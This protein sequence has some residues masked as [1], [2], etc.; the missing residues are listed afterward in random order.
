MLECI[1]RS[2]FKLPFANLGGYYNNYRTAVPLPA[3][4]STR[5][6]RVLPNE[7]SIYDQNLT[8]WQLVK[9]LV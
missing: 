1:F 6:L 5:T 2:F 7:R 8:R 3:P 4:K 9:R